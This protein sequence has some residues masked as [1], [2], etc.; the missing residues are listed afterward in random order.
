VDHKD[1]KARARIEDM[2]CQVD[3]VDG[4]DHIDCKVFK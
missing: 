1:E 4:L 2:F 3:V